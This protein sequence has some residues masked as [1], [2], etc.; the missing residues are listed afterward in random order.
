[1]Y[2]NY[3]E[4]KSYGGGLDEA[5]FCIYGY[6]A[7]QRIKAE[8]HGRIAEASEPVKRC[9]ARLVDIMK[10]ADVSAEKVTS[11]SNDGVSQNIKDVSSEDYQKKISEIIRSYLADEVDE[12]G[13]P[14][15]YLGVGQY[16]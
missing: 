16:D 13:V 11:W 5:A 9:V 14:L 4:Y 1:M 7:E 12:N 2:L 15:L 8:T 3:E 6:E 10:Q